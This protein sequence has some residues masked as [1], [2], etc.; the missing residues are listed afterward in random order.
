MRKN[1]LRNYII[2]NLRWIS[3][4]MKKERFSH[5]FNTMISGDLRHLLDSYKRNKE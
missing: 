4:H 2:R 3:L 1:D 5:I